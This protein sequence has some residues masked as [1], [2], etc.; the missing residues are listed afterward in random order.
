MEDCGHTIEVEGLE[1]WLM[2]ESNEIGMKTCPRCRSSIYNN[3]RY[4]HIIL[5]TYKSVQKVKDL[6][7]KHAQKNKATKK[8][9]KLILQS[10]YA[11]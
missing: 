11:I 9:I 5:E 2:Q 10:E 1:G 7:N 4:Q 8:D 6:Y 3:R